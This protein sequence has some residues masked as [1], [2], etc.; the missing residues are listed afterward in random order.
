MSSA[1]TIRDT[2]GIASSVAPSKEFMAGVELEIESFHN[3]DYPDGWH[4]E[5]DGSLRNNGMEI[6]SCPQ[7]VGK[8]VDGFKHVHV[9]SRFR[10]QNEKFSER[11]SIHVHVNCL[12]LTQEQAKSVVLW[13][14]LFEPVFFAMVDPSR[15]NNIHCVGLDQTMLCEHYRRSLPMYVQRWSKYTALNLLPLNELGTIE[16]R[17]MEG[18]DDPE[19][20]RAWLKTLRNLWQFG[21][22]NILSKQSVEPEAIM[23]A[24]DSIFIDSPI[25]AIRGSVLG[26]I[27]DNLVDIKLALL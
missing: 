18:H 11:T 27:G 1:E 6:I 14:A 21:Q 10:K 26:L 13:Y 8:L 17:H 15:R 3:A 9:N 2:F 19:R 23:G 12:D 16:F 5:E 25:H 22:N 7:T 4:I 24:F 20:F